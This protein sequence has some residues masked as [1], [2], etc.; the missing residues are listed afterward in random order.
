M[1]CPYCEK[2]IGLI[3]RIGEKK[4][5]T[6]YEI[7]KRDGYVRI[8]KNEDE[9]ESLKKNKD[10]KEEICKINYMTL[11]QFEKQ[12]MKRLYE[13]EKGLKDNVDKV[14]YLKENK[15]IRNLTPIS[16]RLLNYILYSHLFFAKIFTNQERFDRYKPKELSWGEFLY[17][18]FE[19]LKKELSKKG[20]ESVEIFMNYIFKDL[21]ENLH[22]KESIDEF[23]ELISFEKELEN[24]IQEKIEKSLEE[25]K[26]YNK[27]IEINSNDKK[28]SINL[29]NEKY[30]KRNYKKE[31]Y[32]YYEYFYYSDFLDENNVNDIISK[33]KEKKFYPILNK[34]LEY[35][36]KKL[37]I[38]DKYSLNKFN[39]FNKVL[40]LISER[41]SN[42]ITREYAEKTPLKETEI[43]K[44][45]EHS[46][47]IDKF[48]IFYNDLKITDNNGHEINLTKKNKLG[49]FVIDDNNE[50]GKSYKNIY[51][52]F[53]KKQNNEIKDLLD[54]K[55]NEGIF[56]NNCRNKIYAQQ[57]KKEEIFTLNSTEKFS[58]ID[59]IYN[60]S[61][62]K[63]IDTHKEQNYNSFEINLSSIEDN[64]TELLL[65]NKK[66]I[67]EDLIIEFNYNNSIFEYKC[68][69]LIKTFNKL[70]KTKDISSEDKEIINKFIKDNKGNLE[71]YKDIIND[72]LSL[73]EFLNNHNK[74]KQDKA[75][76]IIYDII[77]KN[78]INISNDFFSI[79]NEQKK[80]TVNK[81]TELFNYYIQSIFE[82]VKNEINNF[83]EKFDTESDEDYQIMK[84]RHITLL[85]KYFKKEKTLIS[86]ED[87]ESAIK[88]FITLVLFREKDKEN[89]IK[90]NRK[91]VFDYLNS[92]DL[93]N[94]KLYQE[95]QFKED[96]DELK[97]CDIPINHVLFL[98]NFLVIEENE[99]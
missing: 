69:D 13:K 80:L 32:P 22:E 72:F 81:L 18:N 31:E 77:T 37:N 64:M 74:D 68:T 9:I 66:L 43:Y 44:N 76:V 93:W 19:L 94:S 91:N 75:K 92:P 96:F 90:L 11:K 2:E 78:L 36:K 17:K 54:I 38:K 3:K 35:N 15:F 87:L 79:F 58:F 70:Y 95:Q 99:N 47:L 4:E 40:N 83:Q 71:K 85:N 29:L 6:E 98:Y 23:K 60:S 88:K 28:D 73:F 45:A 53:I 97:S 24:L 16:Y 1:K 50:I 7:V 57:I 59:I 55:I 33:K 86:K 34:Y 12:Y 27:I 42:K 21:F 67:Y 82:D 41:Y 8:F 65:K 25:I 84:E 63:K 46:K 14:Y 20:V 5:K 61:Y 51:M 10:K 39:L 26:K 30:D 62:R 49:D 52:E 48:I 89:K 56:N